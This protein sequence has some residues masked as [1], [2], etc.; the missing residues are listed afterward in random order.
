M[1]TYSLSRLHGFPVGGTRDWG[2][3]DTSHPDYLASASDTLITLTGDDDDSITTMEALG[4]LDSRD[5]VIIGDGL[6][7]IAALVLAA[8]LAVC[9]GWT[10]MRHEDLID[11]G[12]MDQGYLVGALRAVYGDEIAALQ[13]AEFKLRKGVPTDALAASAQPAPLVASLATPQDRIECRDAATQAWHDCDDKTF[14]VAVV[15]ALVALGF[16]AGYDNT[17]ALAAVIVEAGDHRIVL[18]WDPM[19]DGFDYPTSTEDAEALEPADEDEDEQDTTCTC[20][21]KRGMGTD[22][23]GACR[24]CGGYA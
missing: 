18:E 3:L 16:R 12:V 14:R 23:D 8:D 6:Y 22:D 24:D 1:P 11:S 2:C 4:V 10:A 5:P 17:C 9:G 15:D 19:I 7:A 13:L 20:G 21:D